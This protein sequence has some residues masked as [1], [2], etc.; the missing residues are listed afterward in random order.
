MAA[1]HLIPAI[2]ELPRVVPAET[3][4]GRAGLVDLWLFFHDALDDPALRAAQDALLAPEE[5]ER[6][7]RYRFERDRRSYLA[8][9]AL[10]RT[11][12]S[13]Y[14]AVAPED[15][16]FAAGEHGK[17]HVAGPGG[18]PRIEFS[19][20]NTAGLVA[21]AVSW[22]HAR[23]GVDTEALDRPGELVT[24][25]DRFF[26]PKEV[27]ALRSL[28]G[29]QQ[30]RRF[31]SYWTLKESYIKARGLGLSL[32]LDQFTFLLDDGPEIGV[33]FD[34]RLGD[35]PSRW[36]FALLDASPRHLVAVGVDTGGAPL[37]LRAARCIPLREAS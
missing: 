17:P 12:L 34:P 32:P 21:C 1:P 13:R 25:A 27:G 29:D 36:R 16:R 37:S 2:H 5:R 19:L 23:V 7:D 3:L 6:R 28:A 18:A 30:R 10:V 22:A 33:A 20:S 11:V 26:S 9:R 4:S 15:W 14:A 31:Y 8:T 24:V 35:E